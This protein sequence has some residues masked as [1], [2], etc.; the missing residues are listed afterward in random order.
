MHSYADITKS[1]EVL[2]FV[3]KKGIDKGLRELIEPMLLGE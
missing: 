3:A 2:H 1:K